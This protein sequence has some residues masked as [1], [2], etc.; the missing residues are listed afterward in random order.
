M[1][2]SKKHK[3]VDLSSLA[4]IEESAVALPVGGLVCPG[5]GCGAGCA[6]LACGGGCAGA[7]CGGLC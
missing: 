1:S 7:G 6:G 3:I 5:L 2:E 4:E